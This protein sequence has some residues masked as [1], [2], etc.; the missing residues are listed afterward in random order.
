VK[1]GSTSLL[2]LSLGLA[3]DLCAGGI[4]R[5]DRPSVPQEANAGTELL[6]LPGEIG[7]NGGRLT[8]VAAELCVALGAIGFTRH[9]C[10]ERLRRSLHD[11]GFH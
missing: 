11:L 5:D 7:R 2:V 6:T 10:I 1:P 4:V 8:E 3:L 9:K